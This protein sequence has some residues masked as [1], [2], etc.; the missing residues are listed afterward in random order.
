MK[1]RDENISTLAQQTSKQKGGGG[2]GN[3]THA[4]Y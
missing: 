1:H 2:G 4:N 3:F